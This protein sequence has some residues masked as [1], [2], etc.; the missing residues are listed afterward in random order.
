MSPD[1]AIGFDEWLDR[2]IRQ[3]ASSQTGPHPM[4]SQARYYAAQVPGGPL[5]SVLVKVAALAS[6]KL[7]TGFTVA[8]VAASAAGAAGEAAI[9]GSANPSDWGRQ[10][11]QQVEKCKAALVPGSH[12]IGECVSTFAS[13]PKS[14]TGTPE[15]P[16]ATPSG[17]R[18]GSP[19]SAGEP[20][21]GKPTSHPG[22]G[23]PSSN[24]GHGPPASPPG[25][26]PPSSNPGHGPPSSPPG[27]S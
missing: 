9:T 13:Q 24:P 14:E 10:V 23:P 3:V 20:D 11:V 8:V 21:N 25:H 17:A 22:G 15:S 27:R 12:G 7:A 5:R 16:G 26:G 19:S 2:E 18:E 6:V 4:P 1:G